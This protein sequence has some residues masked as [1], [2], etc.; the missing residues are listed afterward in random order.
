MAFLLIS[1]A[2]SIS[3][4]VRSINR[5]YN[6]LLQQAKKLLKKVECNTPKTCQYHNDKSVKKE[7]TKPNGSIEL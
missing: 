1:Q 3:P 5:D 2:Q 4:K 7:S 6:P